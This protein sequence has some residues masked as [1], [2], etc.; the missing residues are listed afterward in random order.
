MFLFFANDA[1]MIHWGYGRYLENQIRERYGFTGTPLKVVFRSRESREEH[2]ERRSR[3]PE[4]A[5]RA[6]APA[7]A[8]SDDDAPDGLS[9][10]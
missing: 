3:R 10:D 7:A 6:A 1:E 5:R 8:D 9:D 4:R 2:A